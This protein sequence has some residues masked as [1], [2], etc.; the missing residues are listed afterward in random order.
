MAKEGHA[1]C[2]VAIVFLSVTRDKDPYPHYFGKLDPD[3]YP[4]KSEKLF[5]DPH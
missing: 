1:F 5:P 3:P 4:H 2:V